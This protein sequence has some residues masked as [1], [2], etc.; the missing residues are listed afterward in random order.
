LEVCPLSNILTSVS[1]AANHSFRRLDE[2]GIA[3]AINHDGLNDDS[4]L[5]DEDAFVQTT[6]GY[7]D[8]DMLC[9]EENG[10]NQAFRHVR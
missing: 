8:K 4:I 5:D 7:S 6:F 1:N 10:I 2:A 9:F 3:V